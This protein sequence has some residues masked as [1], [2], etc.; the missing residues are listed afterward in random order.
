MS[1]L[2]FEN[3]PAVKDKNILTEPSGRNT[4]AAIGLA[5][6]HLLKDD[7]QAIM[8]VLS[9]DHLVRPPERLLEIISTGLEIA[10]TEEYLMTI[11]IVPTRAETGYGYIKMGELFEHA[12]KDVVRRVSAFTEKP[13][14]AVANEYYYSGNY[15]WNSGMFIWSAKTIMN[16]INELLPELDDLLK[17]YSRHIGTPD[18]ASAR[19]KLYSEMTS[20]SIDVGILEKADNVLT[21]KADIAWDD[22]GGWNALSRYKTINEDNNVVIGEVMMQNAYETTVYNEGD[23]IIVCI[24]VAD[25]I[26]VKSGNITMVVHKTKTHEIKEVLLRLSEDEKT[27]HYL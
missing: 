15:L 14:V 24:G 5:A 21:I 3:V 7:P 8:V 16:A 12:G 18:E 9:S 4:C 17:T 20:I 11:G 23:G 22:I 10:K 6:V 1:E 27:R 2:I 19:D 25:L 13:K 26:V